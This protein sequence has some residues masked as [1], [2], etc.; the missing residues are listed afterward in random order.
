[1]SLA[2]E[3]SVCFFMR[4]MYHEIENRTSLYEPKIISEETKEELEF[5][6]CI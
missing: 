4:N 2:T 5:R 3:P 1:M 6:V